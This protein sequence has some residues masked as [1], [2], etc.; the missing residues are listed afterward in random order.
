METFE[1]NKSIT[2]EDSSTTPL[3][4]FPD[5][6]K[7]DETAFSSAHTAR[8]PPPPLSISLSLSLSLAQVLADGNYPLVNAGT[9]GS[10]SLG[11]LPHKVRDY[12]TSKYKW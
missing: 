8:H 9:E 4:S 12:G 2:Q 11:E 3:V 6:T 7:I 10:W 5:K 1:G